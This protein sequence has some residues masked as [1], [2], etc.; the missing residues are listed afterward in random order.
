MRH[1]E[2][3]AKN[4]FLY[5]AYQSQIKRYS[6]RIFGIVLDIGCGQ[7]PYT[8]LFYSAKQIIGI[9]IGKHKGKITASGEFLPFRD[10]TFDSAIC[11]Q[12]LEHV[13]EPKLLLRE[14]FRVL[15]SGGILLLTTPFMWGVHSEPHD[16][17]RYT[18]YGLEYL[19]KEAGF[20]VE[21]IETVSGFWLLMALRLNYYLSRLK[22]SLLNPLF[23]LT[24]RIGVF[25]DRLDAK[26]KRRD[27][28]GYITV[29]IKPKLCK[30]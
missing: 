14:I 8:D 2:Q 26:Y 19:A 9:D 24:Q 20:T 18:S 16:Y 4:S 23:W 27:T 13:K 5:K 10:T 3:S 12:T 30:F 21:S 6:D 28:V 25:L 17:Y 29:L 22:T 15:K 11:F 7:M 1:P